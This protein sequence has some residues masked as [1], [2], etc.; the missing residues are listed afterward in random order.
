MGKILPQGKISYALLSARNIEFRFDS[1]DFDKRVYSNSNGVST[2]FY[3][4]KFLSEID[5]KNLL[6]VSK[7]VKF[8]I[9]YVYSD[10]TKESIDVEVTVSYSTLRRGWVLSQLDFPNLDISRVLQ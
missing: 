8:F 10:G 2:I 5:F 3:I 6:A 1:K 9:D 7:V 4:P